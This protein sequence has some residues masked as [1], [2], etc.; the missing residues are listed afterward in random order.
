MMKPVRA[1]I[2][3][4][5]NRVYDEY[6]RAGRPLWSYCGPMLR[7]VSEQNFNFRDYVDAHAECVRSI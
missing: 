7:I 1:A 6:N 2:W 5:V 4:I 3:A